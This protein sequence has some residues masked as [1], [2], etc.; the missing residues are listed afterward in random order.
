MLSLPSRQP[1]KRLN[2]LCRAGRRLDVE[3]T[4]CFRLANQEGDKLLFTSHVIIGS[5]VGYAANR[6]GD[7]S[8]IFAF[9]GGFVSHQLADLI[10]HVDIGSFGITIKKILSKR[11]AVLSVVADLAIG[12]AI[13]AIILYFRLPYLKFIL[14]GAIGGV[15]TDV[16]DNS[17]FWSLKLRKHFPFNYF[18]AI[19]ES[20]HFTVLNKKYF[21]VGWLTQIMLI[22]FCLYLIFI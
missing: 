9:A 13:L 19:H 10:P 11:K 21:W 17:P 14:L 1:L 15:M 18:H 5:A 8:G 22:G 6:A 7:T 4:N 12:S 2:I 20:L 16:V 3:T